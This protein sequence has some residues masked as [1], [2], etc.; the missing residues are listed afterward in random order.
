MNIKR[1][2]KIR[3]HRYQTRDLLM[4]VIL[5]LISSIFLSSCAKKTIKIGL[6]GDLTSKNS[7][8]SIDVRNAV[9][10]AVNQVNENGGINGQLL[11][12]VVKDDH[13]DATAALEMDQAFIKEGVHFVIGHMHS[14]MAD[15]MKLA[16]SGEL[17]FISPTMGTNALS[18]IDDFIIRTAPLNA[19]QAKIFCDYYM[20]NDLKDLVIICD[21]MNQEYTQ[22]IG[23]RVQEIL[24]GN[25]VEIKAIFNYDSRKDDLKNIVD[26]VILEN[27]GTL[28][29]L[30]QAKD[31]AYF[32]KG[33][34]KELPDTS[35]FSVPWSMTKDFIANGGE[36]AEGTKFIGVYHPK[37][38]SQAYLS[39]VDGFEKVY[40]Y[41]PSFASVLGADAFQTLYIGLK[42]AKALTPTEVKKAIIDTNKIQGL[43][44]EFS[45]DK[46]GDDTKGYMLFE[47]INGEYMPIRASVQD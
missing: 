9:E 8:I 2:K 1:E 38:E 32:V 22:S 12:L 39:F 10:Y 29:L 45:I 20:K 42:S 41:K 40:D 25:D 30:S 15:A 14:N 31:S 34:K 36:Y 24:T 21:F 26:Q 7:Q 18:F 23:N 17:L 43:Q 28:L 46:F 16:A 6:I 47:L 27:P 3:N 37:E 33:I 35:I 4:F 19:E 5:V 13:A 44:E 11:E